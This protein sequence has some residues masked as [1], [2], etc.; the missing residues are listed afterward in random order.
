MRDGRRSS[1]CSWLPARPLSG[2]MLFMAR[3]RRRT[4]RR[5]RHFGSAWASSERRSFPDCPNGL[6]SSRESPTV[7]LDKAPRSMEIRRRGRGPADP[8][9]L[10][11][12]VAKGDS[13]RW[14]FSTRT[15]TTKSSPQR[16][17]GCSRFWTR[18]GAEL[19]VMWAQSRAHAGRVP[20]DLGRGRDIS[21][22]E[23][24]RSWPRSSFPTPRLHVA[25]RSMHIATTRP[26]REGAEHTWK[27]PRH[28][29]RREE[30]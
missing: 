3:S 14:S 18:S 7:P 21:R 26:R 4:R 11:G 15:R 2:L 24:G 9:A 25:R 13:G 29:P 8:S 17:S 23:T 5:S 27:P 10:A 22:R 16:T 30:S 6:R 20:R 1:P 28:N 19:T 12:L